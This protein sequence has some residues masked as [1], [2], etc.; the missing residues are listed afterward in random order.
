LHLRVVGF[1]IN[2]RYAVDVEFICE[3]PC[4]LAFYLLG[5]KT[6]GKLKQVVYIGV[7]CGDVTPTNRKKL[8]RCIPGLLI[9]QDWEGTAVTSI[10]LQGQILRFSIA[11]IEACDQPA[12][13]TVV[14]TAQI[15]LLF[16]CPF[17]ISRY[18]TYPTPV[19]SDLWQVRFRRRGVNSEI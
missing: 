12:N 2:I 4:G 8:S 16:M 7:D 9:D 14:A 17:P 11:A 15:S 18:P 5:M 1:A 19:K 3:Q 13:R 6:V 10:T